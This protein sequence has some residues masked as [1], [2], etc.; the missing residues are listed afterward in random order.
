[1]GSTTIEVLKFDRFESVVVALFFG[2]SFLVRRT[3]IER[4][5]IQEMSES[6]IFDAAE[7]CQNFR[8]IQ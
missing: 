3:K 8:R 4:I 5:P 6:Q 7:I 2:C 1:V